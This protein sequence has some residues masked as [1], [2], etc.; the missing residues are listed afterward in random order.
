M[1]KDIDFSKLRTLREERGWSLRRLAEESGVSAS[2]LSF[3][4]RGKTTPTLPRIMRVCDALGLSLGDFDGVRTDPPLITAE[5]HVSAMFHDARA[6]VTILASP[7]DSEVSMFR[8]EIDPEIVQ[9]DTLIT[10]RYPEYGYVIQGELRVL[11]EAE[12]FT[13]KKG[14]F[15]RVDAGL[16]HRFLNPGSSMSVSIWAA[17]VYSSQLKRS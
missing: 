1:G 8:F 3:V 17:P 4:E 9:P 7:R 14:D 15:V 11:L 13:A 12:D 16:G 5:H 10:H 2:Y 6:R